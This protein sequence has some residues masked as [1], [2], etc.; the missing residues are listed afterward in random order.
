MHIT[1][2]KLVIAVLL[3]FAAVGLLFYFLYSKKVPPQPIP[4]EVTAPKKEIIGKSVDGRNIEAYIYGNGDTHLVFVGGI[5]G[6][7]EWNSVV[8]AYQMI[9]YFDANPKII[10]ENTSVTII[11]VLNPDGVFKIVGKE[12][13]FVPADITQT[14]EQ[15]AL[16]RFNAHG[17]DLNRNFDCKWQPEST[18]QSKIVSAGTAPFSEPEA[19]AF[20]DFVFKTK[21]HVVVFWHSKAG[22]VYASQ[23]GSGI[24]TTTRDVMNVYAKAGNY[25]AVDIFD[26]YAVTGAAED[27]L[28]SLNI[29]AITVELKTHDQT[30]FDANLTAVKALIET[31]K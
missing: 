2:S 12:G 22:A 23:C 18:W 8:L 31:Y 16:G 14:R 6:G 11:P 7:Y 1:K 21:P 13:R 26:A 3:I 10:P 25:P 24:P 15:S 29:P 28:A 5:H 17:V 30:E 19:I 4:V 27:W 9:D 20:R